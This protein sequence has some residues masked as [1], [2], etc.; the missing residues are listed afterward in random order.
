MSDLDRMF[1]PATKYGR[2]EWV[3]LGGGERICFAKTGVN[4][5]A[6]LADDLGCRIS[7]RLRLSRAF[8]GWSWEVRLDRKYDGGLI[9]GSSVCLEWGPPRAPWLPRDEAVVAGLR[10][11]MVAV[12]AERAKVA[13]E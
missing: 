6:T 1:G 5:W 7:V 2:M 3:R 12:A 13:A 8:G 9:S 4:E 11:A 10:R